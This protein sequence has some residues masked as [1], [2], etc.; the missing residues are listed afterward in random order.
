MASHVYHGDLG[1][2]GTI[3]YDGCEECEERAAQGIQGLLTQ[4]PERVEAI[5][6]RMLVT[7]G[8]GQGVEDVGRYPVKGGYM[9]NAEA[10][11]GRSLYYLA[12][13]YERAGD[14]SAWETCR[15]IPAPFQII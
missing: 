7:E 8:H 12:V 13:L 3:F 6:R 14:K 11:V 15:F 1:P 4:D 2:E 9:S 10:R 5:W